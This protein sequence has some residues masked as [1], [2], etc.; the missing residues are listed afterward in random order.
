M[1]NSKNH[2]LGSLLV[3]SVLASNTLWG[4]GQT[5]LEFENAESALQLVKDYTQGVKD[6]DP[7]KMG[8]SLAENAIIYG[9]GN[10]SDSLTA[11][12]HKAYF[13]NSFATYTHELSQELYLPVKV[14]D[15]WNEGEWVLSWGT[16]NITHKTNGKKSRIPYHT[17]SL[18]ENGKIRAIYYFY[19]VS[20]I[21]LTQ[22]FKI[23]PP[24]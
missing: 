4:Q 16:D 19:D 7:D 11:E 15:N 21:L 12:D 14:T 5:T 9:L 3:L 18:V 20:N 22:G 23:T 10:G 8:A 1:K 6:A 17:A 24:E 2:L 13:T